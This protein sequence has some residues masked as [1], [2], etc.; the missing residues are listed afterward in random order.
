LF[1]KDL[2]LCGWQN[3]N[4]GEEKISIQK[5]HL[6]PKAY[7]CVVIFEPRIFSMMKQE[8]KFSLVDVYLDLAA[9]NKIL[10][11]DHTGDKFVDVGKP[12]A[13]L[14]AEKLFQ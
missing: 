4:T 14:L 1:D 8:G 12:E 10:A 3:T 2:R 5:D 9:K 13:L 7:S 6:L 11:F